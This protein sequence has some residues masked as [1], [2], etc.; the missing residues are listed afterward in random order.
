MTLRALH[1]R[2]KSGER[3]ACFGVVELADVKR[4]PVLKVMTGLAI[5]SQSPFV[6]IF[7]TGDARGGKAEIGAIQILYLDCSAFLRRDVRWVMAL[8]AS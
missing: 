5:L 1:L 4:F 7:V 3:I 6:L 2:V 8:V